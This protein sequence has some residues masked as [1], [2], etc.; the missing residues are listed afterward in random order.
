MLLIFAWG[1][2]QLWRNTL[3]FCRSERYSRGS[4]KRLASVAAFKVHNRIHNFKS[5]FYSK[6]NYFW[7]SPF[8]FFLSS[9]IALIFVLVRLGNI[10]CVTRNLNLCMIFRFSCPDRTFSIMLKCWKTDRR[11]RWTFS[12][13]RRMLENELRYESGDRW[14]DIGATVHDVVR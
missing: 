6:R 3:P 10:A 4:S 9:F 7:F 2:A 5:S 12:A 1:R 11:T 13:L 14:R 8:H